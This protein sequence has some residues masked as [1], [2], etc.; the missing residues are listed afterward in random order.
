[1]KQHILGAA[2]TI[3]RDPCI[4]ITEPEL[5]KLLG[6]DGVLVGGRIKQVGHLDLVLLA[7]GVALLTQLQTMSCFT[8]IIW[9]SAQPAWALNETSV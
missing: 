2:S 3:L 8:A 6:D 9:S 4:A 1:M 5:V 7:L